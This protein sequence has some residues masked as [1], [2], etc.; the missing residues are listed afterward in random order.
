MHSAGGGAAAGRSR[1]SQSSQSPSH[2]A[3][4]SASSSARQKRKYQATVSAVAPQIGG[5]FAVPESGVGSGALASNDDMDSISA[6]EEEGEE[7]EEEEDE[8]EEGE[9]DQDSMR[10]FTAAR[11]EGQNAAGV[12][13][14]GGNPR[15]TKPPKSE[16]PSAMSGGGGSEISG[17]D[18]R[19]AAGQ[20]SVGNAGGASVKEEA[21]KG[22]FTDNLQTSGAYCA[23]EEG[24]K[25]EASPLH[26]HHHLVC[27][28]PSPLCLCQEFRQ[29][30]VFVCNVSKQGFRS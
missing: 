26:Y 9:E 19:G 23:R 7:Y 8:D 11:L 29:C 5:P 28:L 18:D 14:G 10:T 16:N 17:K 3:T 6:K 25:R 12:A 21:A 30:R 24:L 22:I 20:S 1:S 15:S 13:G 2:S 4:A 27:V